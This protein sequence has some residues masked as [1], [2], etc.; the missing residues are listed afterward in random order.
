MRRRGPGKADDGEV[1]H[2]GDGEQALRQEGGERGENRPATLLTPRRN[3][4]SGSRQ[5]R[6]SKAATAMAAEVRRR[7][8]R[9]GQGSRVEAAAAGF[10]GLRAR[11]GVFIGRP[12]V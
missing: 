2:G 5:Q 6:S 9:C 8:Q 7:R 1:R 11:G 10:A 12:R 4:S 3:S